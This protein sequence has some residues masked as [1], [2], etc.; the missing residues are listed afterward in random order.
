MSIADASSI[1][2]TDLNAMTTAAQIALNAD[3]TAA[4]LGFEVN[5]QFANVVAGS[6]S[7]FC[8]TVF[9]VPFDCYLE[10]LAVTTGDMTN[11]STVTVT[12]TGD[13]ALPNWPTTVTGVVG[14][15]PANMARL[16]YDNTKAG[17]AG[18]DFA[19]VSRAFR[20]YPKG[21]TVTVQASSSSVAAA[22]LLQAA[23]VFRQIW[24]RE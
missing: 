24:G 17:A 3:A 2:A 6:T 21:S 20:V 16:L 4:P 22:S 12:I 11:P 5:L 23:L 1:I 14:A 18:V 9:V 15:S 7:R 13:G 8:K 19:T 10:T